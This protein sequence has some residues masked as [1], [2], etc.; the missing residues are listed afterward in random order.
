MLAL[1][2]VLIFNFILSLFF[3]YFTVN[4]LLLLTQYVYTI[5]YRYMHVTVIFFNYFHFI[6]LLHI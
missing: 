5:I 3:I 6:F 4:Q 2:S 1:R